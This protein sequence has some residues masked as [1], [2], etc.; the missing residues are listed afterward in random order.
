MS[1]RVTFTPERLGHGT[2][3]N[4]S[5]QIAAPADSVP[6]P[7]TT[8]DI[9][10]PRQLGVATGGLGLSTCTQATLQALGPEGCPANSRMGQGTATA[11]I[12]I[13]PIIIRE[14]AEVAI[15]RGPEREGHLALLFYAEGK[16]PVNAQ[17]AFPG[18]LR[19]GPEGDES[20][21]IDVPLVPSVPE[22]PDV[23]V[24]RLHATLGP[25]GLTYYEHTH[26]HTIAYRPQGVLLP[27]KCPRGGFA[28][29][30]TFGFLDGSTTNAQATVPC[31]ARH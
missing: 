24:V 17:I 12:P 5:A 4:V 2:T 8:L 20:I 23:A 11:E 3:V 10:Y 16:T 15:I 22:G 6:P 7:L 13:G 27:N 26:G 31:P 9:H 25:R 19:P 21:H 30:A 29:S 28:F 14:T 18:L 1:F